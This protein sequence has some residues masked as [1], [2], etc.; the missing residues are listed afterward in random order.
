MT[1]TVCKKLIEIKE[2]TQDEADDLQC[3]LDVFLLNDRIMQEEYEE[4][5][6]MLVYK[7]NGKLK[8]SW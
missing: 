4:L 3:K 2:F 7:I 1:Y 8:L 6:G 5:T